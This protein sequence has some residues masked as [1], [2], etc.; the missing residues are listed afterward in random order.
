MRPIVVAASILALASAARAQDPGASLTP[1]DKKSGGSEKMHMLAHIP[2][3]SGKWKASDV[4]LEQDPS[5]PYVYLCGF[6]NYNFQIYDI[7]QVRE[8]RR[9]SS[10][11]RSRIPSCIAGSARWTGST[12][13]S[14]IATTTSSRSNSSRAVPTPTS[15]R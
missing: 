11:G 13:R 15:A 2:G 12:S 9:R 6:V 1:F 3:Y 4:E 8:A 10:N 7:A 5:R 14:A